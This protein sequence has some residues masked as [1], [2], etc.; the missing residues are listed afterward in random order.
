M[1]GQIERLED[2]R[3]LAVT[4]IEQEFVYQLNRARHDPAAYAIEQGLS[5][6]LSSVDARGPLAINP[7]LSRSSDTKAIDLIQNDYF[8]HVSPDGVF[9]NEL[10]ES[11]GYDLP[12]HFGTNQNYV[13]SLAAGSNYATAFDAL[14]ALIVDEGVANVGHR[15]HLL[16]IGDFYGSNR[17]I[18]V[19]YSS[20]SN[21]RYSNYWAVH[22]AQRANPTNL[23]TGVVFDDLNGDGRY[24][25]G[26]GLSSVSIT[27]NGSTSVETNAAGGWAIAVD[28]GHH[29][30]VASGASFQGV[31]TV[32]AIVAG[33][34]VEIDFL[35]GRVSGHVAFQEIYGTNL[36][37]PIDVN[38]SG[39]A[40][41]IDALAILNF[42]GSAQGGSTPIFDEPVFLD[43]NG[44]GIVSSIDALHVINGLGAQSNTGSGEQ[45]QTQVNPI[46]SRVIPHSQPE[47]VI[48]VFLLDRT[49]WRPTANQHP[50]LRGSDSASQGTGA[51]VGGDFFLRPETVDQVLEKAASIVTE[52]DVDW[53]LFPSL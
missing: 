42:L 1:A 12:D 40:S 53:L 21:A 45:I 38:A 4:V 35:S 49:R 13:E 22:I 2:R 28:D 17:E 41:A 24:N 18:G 48:D 34:N 19:G 3:L 16:G 23:L 8:A 32:D 15:R 20:S 33:E 6:D 7:P 11:A 10:V 46:D 31:S 26:E 43:A 50:G 51:M 44:D 27:V 52:I 37:N 25:A 36:D 47:S 30:I 9:P 5:V 29:T 39:S 14:N